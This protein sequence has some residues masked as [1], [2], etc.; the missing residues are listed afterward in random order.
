MSTLAESECVDDAE[1][2]ERIAVLSHLGK[3]MDDIKHGRVT[4]AGKVFDELIAE[5]SGLSCCVTKETLV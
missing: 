1:R 5:L 2:E 4:D 3:S